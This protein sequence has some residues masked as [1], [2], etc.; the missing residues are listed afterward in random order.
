MPVAGIAAALMADL[1]QLARFL[2]RFH[3]LLGA[4]E[5]IGHLFFA[6]DV[7]S[8]LKAG[9]CVRRM[10]EVRCCDDD[11]VKVFFLIEHFL[12]VHIRIVLVAVGF[13]HT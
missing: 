10:P 2:R 1:Q 8:G 4:F 5:R 11:R 12:V 9:H 7:Q 3:H 6:I 13:E